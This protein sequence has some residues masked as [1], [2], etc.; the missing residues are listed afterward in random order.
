MEGKRAVI[1]KN[2]NAIIAVIFFFAILLLVDRYYWAQISQWREDQATNIW[3]GY[4]STIGNM[5]VGL[6]S[7]KDIPNPNGMILLGAIL[8][9]LPGLISV[10]FFLGFV[11]IILVALVG[12]K[13]FGSD[14]RY[15]LLATVPP[16]FS[17]V[18]RS[19][20]V[21]FWN[22]YV[23]TLV[24]IFFIFWAVKYL[25]DRSLWN[26]PPIITM[27][28]LAPSL[29]LAGVVNA[30][31]MTILTVAI[32][33]YKRPMMNNP[34]PV[35]IVILLLVSSS[36]ILTWLP[37]FQN[38]G[39]EQ[40]TNYSKTRLGPVAMF[41]SAWE[42]LFGLP[43][44]ATFQWADRS[45]LSLAIKHADPRILS[46]TSQFLLKLI[47][48]IHLVQ[49]VFAF[50][51]FAY[52]LL[53]ALMTNKAGR[54]SG[55]LIIF[56][57]ARVVIL[58]GLFIGTS[59]TL[60]A[61]LGGPA[62]MDGERPDQIVQFFPMFL[63]IIFLL[64]TMVAAGGKAKKIITGTSFI[65][66]LLFAAVNL[67]GGITIMRDHLQYRGNALTEADVPLIHKMQVV[68]FIAVDWKKHSNSNIIP[69]DYDLGGGVWDW[70]PE[71]GN[72]LLQW[73]PAPMTEGRGF[74]YELLR[75]Y[76]LT[77][78]Q[79]GTQ[80]RAFGNGRYL[81][82]YAFEDSPQIETGTIDHYIF[83]RLRV[84]ILEK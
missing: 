62:W 42:S 53:T 28:L 44:Y 60:S 82:T 32:I 49:A 24:N 41:Q 21:E 17:I 54:E 14:W 2:R 38:V 70:V 81:V 45:T 59:Y 48:R 37:Y 6:I 7:S 78:Q 58:S 67:L 23:M 47:G 79:E 66:L 15:I 3:L 20:S 65:L 30:I 39:L 1:P 26:L 27:I 40:I 12:L 36:L 18:L 57:I 72:A 19:S 56:P 73:Y 51:A 61:W 75:R 9:V 77:N 8:S 46:A 55:D 52:T 71:F 68:D 64:P 31:A 84:S 13:S 43:I 63:F 29:Y 11:Q 34:I 10:S 22:Q 35:L 4:T 76:G 69:V 74:D 50:I 5:P 16:L 25:E 80:I 33:I 83:G